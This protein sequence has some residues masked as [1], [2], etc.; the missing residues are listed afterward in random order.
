M[1]TW[2]NDE[3]GMMLSFFLAVPVVPPSA[4]RTVRHTRRGQHYVPSNVK[5][6]DQ[7]VRLFARGHTFTTLKVP[8]KVT[9]KVYLAKGQ[10]G[11]ADNFQKPLLDAL[12]KCGVIDTDARVRQ[13]TIRKERDPREP[14][15]EIT[16]E[17]YKEQML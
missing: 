7:A 6:F 14:R 16:V 11:D 10:R 1:P 8:L 12:V 13:C 5:A 9:A 15:T 17:I 3:Q 4:N 2:V